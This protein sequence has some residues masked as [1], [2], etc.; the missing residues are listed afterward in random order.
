MNATKTRYLTNVTREVYKKFELVVSGQ[1]SYL[2]LIQS[3]QFG[4]ANNVS[5]S[6][7]P[8]YTGGR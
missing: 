4:L 6:S 7:R 1:S 8:L 5:N 2:I 3:R